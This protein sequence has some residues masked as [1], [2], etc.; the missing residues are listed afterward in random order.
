MERRRRGQNTAVGEAD[1]RNPRYR[2]NP[3]IA[4]PQPIEPRS[5]G[6]RSHTGIASRARTLYY[7]Y[8]GEMEEGI[9]QQ[10]RSFLLSSFWDDAERK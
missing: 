4:T 3:R 5:G 8:M 9:A 6:K 1:R 10:K 2:R 7:M